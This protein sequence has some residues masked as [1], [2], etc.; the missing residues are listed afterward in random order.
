MLKDQGTLMKHDLLS[1]R[2]VNSSFIDIFLL[3]AGWYCHIHNGTSYL[4]SKSLALCAKANK[5]NWEGGMAG[6]GGGGVMLSLVTHAD[7]VRIR[8]STVGWRQGRGGRLNLIPSLGDHQC[9]VASCLGGLSHGVPQD[10]VSPL[11]SRVKRITSRSGP[12][13][14]TPLALWF[15]AKANSEKPAGYSQLDSA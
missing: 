2:A 3:G 14:P 7:L 8:R 13:V 12:C 6:F 9:T 1:Q 5:L 11:P 10:A 4:F 15:I